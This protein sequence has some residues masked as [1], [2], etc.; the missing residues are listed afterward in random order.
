VGLLADIPEPKIHDDTFRSQDQ[1]DE[2]TYAAAPVWQN[3]SHQPSDCREAI[4]ELISSM[5][6][7]F[8]HGQRLFWATTWLIAGSLLPSS[9]RCKESLVAP[10][11][12]EK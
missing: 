9:R 5:L 3:P 6:V 11:P 10:S 8:T 7:P 2:Q 12:R 4:R 1:V